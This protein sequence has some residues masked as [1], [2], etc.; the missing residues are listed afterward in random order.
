ME[1]LH[2]RC[3]GLDISKKDADCGGMPTSWSGAHREDWLQTL[4]L[5]GASW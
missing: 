2:A 1:V 4:A 5:R 3:A